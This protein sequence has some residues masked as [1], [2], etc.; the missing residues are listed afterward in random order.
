MKKA[1]KILVVVMLVF[2]A[3]GQCTHV[4]AAN[5][6]ASKKYEVKLNK[7]VYTMKKGKTVKLKAVVSKSAKGKKV[8]WTSSNQKVANVSAKGKV[9]AKKKGKTTITAKLKGTKVKA[10]CKITVG[11]PVNGIRLAQNA[12]SLEPGVKFQIKATLSPKKPSNKKL[13][14]TSGN[15]QVVSVSSKGVVTAKQEG[16]AK[17]TVAAAD[18]SGKKAVCNV[19][20]AKKEITVSSVT[21]SSANENLEPGQQ[22]QLT[23]SVN[24]ANATNPSIQWT[25]S[26]PNVVSVSQTGLVQATGEGTATI[27]AAAQNGVGADCS[28]KVSYKGDVS[29]QAELNQALSS[30]MLT[31]IRYTSAQA[32]HITI[33]EGDYSSKSLEIYAPNADVT[34]RGRFAK[35][36]VFAIAK[37]T[38]TEHANNTIDF[39]APEG[40]I[41][42]GERGIAF[43]NLAGTAGQKFNLENNG[44]VRDLQVPSQASLTIGGQNM[45]P[46]T[47]RSGAGGTKIV[48]ETELSVR[49]SAQWNMTILPGAE[50]TKATVD[51]QA[52]MPSIEGIGCIPVTVS[53]DQ[54]IVHIPAQMNPELGIEQKVTVS[55]NIMEY[56]LVNDTT[57][58]EYRVQ[59]EAS[60]QTSIYM[61]SY[62]ASNRDI[63]AENYMD[64]I[65]GAEAAAITDEAGNYAIPDVLVGNYW[66]IV[67]KEHFRPMI[68]NLFITSF[69]TENYANSQIDLLSDAFIGISN[70]PEIS[71]TIVDALTG[72][73]VNTAGITVKLRA[74]SGNITG[75]AEKTAVTDQAGGYRFT[76]VPAGV[77]TVEAIDVRQ[78]LD[79]DAIRYNHAATTVVVAAPYLRSDNYNLIM[80]QQMQSIT[81][82]GLVQFTLEWGDEE[83]GASEDIDSHLI[84][85]RYNGNGT[86]HVY[87]HDQ[88]YGFWD[89][90]ESEYIRYA[91]LDVDDTDYE[92]PEHTTIYRETPGIYRFYIRNYT[93]NHSDNSDKMAKSSIKV[94]VT[95][96]ASSYTYYCPNQVGNLWYVCDY[97][98]I[99]HTI[100]PKNIVSTFLGDESEVG[101]TQEELD[102]LYLESERSNA[103]DAV[104]SF[105][106]YLRY[107]KDNA[108]KTEYLNQIAAWKNQISAVDSYQAAKQLANTIEQEHEDLTDIIR[109][110]SISADQLLDYE[111]GTFA[112]EDLGVYYREI[113]CS[114]LSGDVLIDLRVN[115]YGQEAWSIE[116]LS[117]PV[118]GYRYILHL[119][120]DNGLSCDYRIGLVDGR[121]IMASTIRKEALEC[122]YVLDMFEDCTDIQNSRAELTE[123]QNRVPSIA[124][125]SEY[126]EIRN[127]IAEIKFSYQN[128]IRITSV[129][130]D[131]LE[132]WWTTT[133][134]E[135]DEDEEEIIG[136]KFVLRIER[137]EDFSS[138]EI[139]GK[140]QI[141]FEETGATYTMTEL[142]EDSYYQALLKVQNPATGHI[143]KIYINITIW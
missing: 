130:A 57:D 66:L 82:S 34:N 54:D 75:M 49:S 36:S 87:Y 64:Y 119:T 93:E 58:G 47:L 65:R 44:S 123:L 18:G 134:E 2:L 84:G 114:V 80:T 112:D 124:S 25:S 111:Y 67:Q 140:L 103:F 12:V 133:Y 117:D 139:L 89:D 125:E 51:S 97:N 52:C 81:G 113:I 17:I 86:F 72:E 107:F 6:S 39:H 100:I 99:T 41:V 40:R 121:D 137:D 19:T 129:N 5:K 94:T 88:T 120:H 96:G 128:E 62:H 21:I 95:I 29:N 78:G 142:G 50:N 1:G 31:N 122:N 105:E 70:T 43:I 135:T 108:K 90:E 115:N 4:F 24:P 28:F 74:G 92:G 22:K 37:N 136:K 104:S 13:T 109:Y 30:K 46:V 9:T 15:K 73:S 10:S 35:V 59:S 143:K 33:P 60:A 91:D 69:Q 98:A 77:Y 127:R 126:Q 45:V 118:D 68:Q 110:P 138:A 20:V 76:D 8:V 3:F 61:L 53:A 16:T 63:N 7:T 56:D 14:F 27:R 71:G 55:G 141:E 42:I 83:S 106:D 26:N 48:T 102:D 32:G 11:T 101:M 23:A 79:T 131:G 132:D 85:P 116:T 38:Y